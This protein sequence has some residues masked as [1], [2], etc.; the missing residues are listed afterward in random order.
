MGQPGDQ[1]FQSPE[2]VCFPP[3][4]AKLKRCGGTAK[5]R[6]RKRGGKGGRDS[7]HLDST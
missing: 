7:E 2:A 6:R 3:P 1:V 4:G 5:R